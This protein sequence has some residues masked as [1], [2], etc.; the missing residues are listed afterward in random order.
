MHCFGAGWQQARRSLD[1]GFLV[2][3]AGNLTY[4][5]AQPLRDVAAQ[6]PFDGILVETDAPWLA[7]M[8]NRGKRNEPAWVT[9]TAQV[10]AGLLN[11][12]AEELAAATTKNF[13]RLFQLGADVGNW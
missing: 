7:P 13:A 11:V 9:Q 6:M 5:K 4:P 10:L 3:F 8:P 2:S 12:E 1:L